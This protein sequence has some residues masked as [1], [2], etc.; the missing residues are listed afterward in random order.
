L[1]KWVKYQLILKT[2]PFLLNHHPLNPREITNQR[3]SRGRKQRVL[4]LEQIKTN[5]VAEIKKLKKRVKKLEGK[6][7]KRTHG[8]KRLYK[9]EKV[10]KKEVSTDDP[11]TSAGEVFTT[12]DV[13][14]SAA[15]TT[16]TTT[17]DE[18]TL[19]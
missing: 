8:L 16:T 19:V 15:L 18:L 14:V 5:Q 9:S 12:A 13:E 3:G 1:K 6:K 17:D 2:H 4:S 10:A 7:K 11:V